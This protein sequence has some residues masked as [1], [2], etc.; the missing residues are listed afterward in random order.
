MDNRT[1]FEAPYEQAF[2]AAAK[3]LIR[4]THSAS[5]RRAVLLAFLRAP[6][7]DHARRLLGA[8]WHSL[9]RPLVAAKMQRLAVENPRAVPLTW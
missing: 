9:R 1:L 3:E 8:A 7:P 6:S 4:S 5:H 2:Y